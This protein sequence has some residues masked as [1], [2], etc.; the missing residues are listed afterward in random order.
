MTGMATIP[1]LDA[2]TV[3]QTLSRTIGSLDAP[4]G[5]MTLLTSTAE[6]HGACLLLEIRLPAG[7]AGTRPNHYHPRQTE[8]FE[9]L[10]GR[11]HLR[12][13][14]D[15][16]VLGHGDTAFVPARTSHC[17]YTT[18]SP[19]TLRVELRPAGDFERGLRLSAAA[20]KALTRH[21]LLIAL[22]LQQTETYYPGV[23]LAVQ[24]A[25]VAPL[26]ALA[27]RVYGLRLARYGV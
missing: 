11:L 8:R 17:F 15:Q 27:R 23:P 10:D 26:A 2:D 6:S 1:A 19:A 14:T 12:V 4:G 25:V 22:V 24:R 13:G 9:V 3:E 21:P 5:L 20:G 18:D 16:R 7:A